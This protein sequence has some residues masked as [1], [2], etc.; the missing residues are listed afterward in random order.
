MSL[1]ESFQ[2]TSR[3]KNDIHNEVQS[4][5]FSNTVQKSEKPGNGMCFGDMKE[6]VQNEN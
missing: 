3:K 6:L 1:D 2:S 5:N 4:R